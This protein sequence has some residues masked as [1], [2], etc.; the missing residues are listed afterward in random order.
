MTWRRGGAVSAL[1]LCA[2]LSACGGKPDATPTAVASTPATL[3]PVNGSAATTETLQGGSAGPTGYSCSFPGGDG[4]TILARFTLDGAN[5]RD[6]EGLAFR[7][8]A[9]SATAVVLARPRDDVSAPSGDVG[10][11]VVAIDKRDLS[12]VQSTV[13]VKGAGS[14]RKGRC[15]TG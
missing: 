2:C 14:S 3:Q 15:I 13:G 12:M 10:A 8:L 1:G 5:A 4:R 9:N 6:D 11:Y 7:V